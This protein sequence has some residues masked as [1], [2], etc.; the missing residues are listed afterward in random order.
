MSAADFFMTQGE[1]TGLQRRQLAQAIGAL[2]PRAQRWVQEARRHEPGADPSEL[3]AKAWA[4]EVE[5]TSH[6]PLASLKAWARRNRQAW[7]TGGAEEEQAE[8]GEG[9]RRRKPLREA[10]EATTPLDVLLAWE[11]VEQRL[12]ADPQ[13]VGRAQRAADLEKR[14]GWARAVAARCRIS[15]RRVQQEFDLGRAAV[16]RGQMDLF[17][18]QGSEGEG[19]V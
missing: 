19:A 10:V 4:I 2:S 17:D 18:D 14:T 8:D 12:A 13:A 15:T 16:E 11:V 9:G 7:G 3:V 6:R 5:G 1:V